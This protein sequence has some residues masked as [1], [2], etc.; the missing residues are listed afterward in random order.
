[1]NPEKENKENIPKENGY[2][3]LFIK[4]NRKR[5]RKRS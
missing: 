2:F 1:M 5:S 3:Y 4:I